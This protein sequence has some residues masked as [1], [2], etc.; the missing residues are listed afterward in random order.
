M[1]RGF[2][3]AGLLAGAWLFASPWVY[4]SPMSGSGMMG[5]HMTGAMQQ[6]K[7]LVVINASTYYW[8]IVPGLLTILV[9]ATVVIFSGM[10]LLRSL[11]VALGVLAVWSAAGPWVLPQLGMGDMMM[12]GVTTGS[13]L[14]HILP[15]IA[16]AVCALGLF[17]LMP[18]RTA[19]EVRTQARVQ[20]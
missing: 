1:R 10:L 7:S 16:L 4:A 6:E 5:G 9:S 20:G 14:R 15:G 2:G 12:S 11:A 17:F 3:L 8:H 18:A 19:R 13:F